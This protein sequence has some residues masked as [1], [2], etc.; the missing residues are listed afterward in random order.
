MALMGITGRGDPWSCEGLMTQDR[1]LRLERVGE[2]GSTL[3]EAGGG[4]WDRGFWREN[5]ERG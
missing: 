1:A 4:E 5:R 3:I 2:W